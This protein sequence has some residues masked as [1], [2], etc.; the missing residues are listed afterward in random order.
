MP[1]QTVIRSPLF[2]MALVG[3]GAIGFGLMPLFARAAY[4]EGLSPLSLLVWRFAIAVFCC[5]PW[6][7]PILAARRDF[8]IAL[9][10]GSGYMASMLF[11]F[12]AL[13]ELSVA[14]TVL[15]LF[16]Y[17]LFTILI[18]WL[19]FGARLTR[20][21]LIAALLVLLAAGLILSPETLHGAPLLPVLLAFLPPLAYALFIHLAAGR[22][23]RMAIPVRLS[24][25]FSGGLLAMLVITLAWEG[26]IP[27]PASPIAWGAAAALALVSTFG[28][29]GLLL[30]GA[31]LA[32]PE[33]SAIAGAG[34][35]ITSLLIGLLAFAEPI[36]PAMLAGAG[37]ILAA[38]YVSARM[39]DEKT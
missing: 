8:L 39:T 17:P 4:A 36:S 20:A 6:L 28:A 12:V 26:S 7:G 23:S 35:L 30:L 16:T 27:L 29:L 34:E 9:L 14:L 1:P 5:L 15:I 25:V 18:G 22:L 2:G 24:G 10:T 33:R 21:N 13:K 19:G 11:Y 3:F 38:I 32:G 37:L 31:P